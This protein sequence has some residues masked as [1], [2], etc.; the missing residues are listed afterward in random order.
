M[1]SLRHYNPARCKLSRLPAV[2]LCAYVPSGPCARARHG[3]RCCSRAPCFFSRR[4]DSEVRE[5]LV[6]AKRLRNIT[7][8]SGRH[9]LSSS[10]F[11]ARGHHHDR[12]VEAGSD[13]PAGL[14]AVQ[15]RHLPVQEN[16]RGHLRLQQAQRVA[17][18]ARLDHIMAPRTQSDP[19]RA[20]KRG[21]VVNN[22]DSRQGFR[23]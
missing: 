21:L 6:E 9:C 12:N 14:Q 5:Q 13:R 10:G 22:Q 1:N 23:V 17:P 16:Q 4:T 3:F 8:R 11:A 2:P 7:G 18:A 15:A 19:D 20:A